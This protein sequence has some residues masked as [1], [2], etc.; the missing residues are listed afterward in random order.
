MQ[1]KF[2]IVLYTEK[3]NKKVGEVHFDV[4][5]YL[6]ERNKKGKKYEVPLEKCPDTNS[7]LVFNL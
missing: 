5:P 1:T 4:A 2:E 6:N 7:R 3:G